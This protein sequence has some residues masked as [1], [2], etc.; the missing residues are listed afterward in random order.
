MRKLWLLISLVGTAFGQAA[1]VQAV[2]SSSGAISNS[3][4]VSFPTL[5]GVGHAVY[6]H[7]F[8]NQNSSTAFTVASPTDNQTGNTYAVT[9]T[10]QST[11]DSARALS[12]IACGIVVGSSGTFTVTGHLSAGLTY[13]EITLVE[14][15]NGTCTAD[16]TVT[17]NSGG[18]VGST[19]W[20]TGTTGISTTNANDIILAGVSA[21]IANPML[22][23]AGSGYV[24]PAGAKQDNESCCGSGTLEYK[25]VSS[26]G[27]YSAVI[28][29]ISG[30]SNYAGVSAAFKQSGA[31]A[32]TMIHH[33]VT[34][35]Q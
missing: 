35:G 6:I 24:M 9:A 29:S 31:A 10:S 7:I 16:G 2:T 17:I 11:V 30:S 4:S 20:P 34:G 19:P 23:T 5:P 22:F 25:I 12:A 32:P 27:T 33:Q 13:L 15:T 26:T 28:T 18:S 21:A 14:M 1:F 8:G 3:V